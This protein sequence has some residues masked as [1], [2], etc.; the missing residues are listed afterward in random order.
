MVNHGMTVLCLAT[1]FPLL[2]KIPVMAFISPLF[3]LSY[4]IQWNWPNGH[5]EHKFV[6]MFSGLHIEMAI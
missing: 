1:T 4:F 5:G 3:A 2:D 6:S